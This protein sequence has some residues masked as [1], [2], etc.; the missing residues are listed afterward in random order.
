MNIGIKLLMI[1]F[2]SGFTQKEYARQKSLK[3]TTLGYWVRK[4]QTS[5]NGFV[6]VKNSPL[7]TDQTSK[8]EI[9]FNKMKIAITGTYDEELLLQV[10]RTVKNV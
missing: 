8:I 3:L 2:K 10:L 1:F 7:V 6:E 4:R 5:F 9:S